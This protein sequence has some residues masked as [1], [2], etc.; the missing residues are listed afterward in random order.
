M[1]LPSY[2]DARCCSLCLSWC[3]S[4]VVHGQLRMRSLEDV[5]KVYRSLRDV[6]KLRD[7]VYGAVGIVC[8][9]VCR[10]LLWST[11]VLFLPSLCAILAQCQMLWKGEK[12]I[13]DIQN[14]S[15]PVKTLSDVLPGPK[16]TSSFYIKYNRKLLKVFRHASSFYSI[17]YA[18][19]A[20]TL[21]REI[22]SHLHL[23]SPICPCN[24]FLQIEQG[25]VLERWTDEKVTF[26]YLSH[27]EERGAYFAINNSFRTI[28]PHKESY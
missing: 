5:L 4:K 22:P 18:V 16:R 11:C 25:A 28:A 17:S 15:N 9:Q 19:A 3:T 12:H 1:H 8:E 7:I 26:T 24:S 13:S 10:M 2:P 6:R 23:I 27:W 21:F 14:L 20:L